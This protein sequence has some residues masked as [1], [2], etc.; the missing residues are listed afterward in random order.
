LHPEVEE[1][2]PS[3]VGDL[4][5]AHGV[6]GALGL[7][8]AMSA[9]GVSRARVRPLLEGAVRWLSA[10]AVTTE[11][12]PTFPTWIA[13]G[14][15]PKPARCAWCYG[16]PGIAAALLVAARGAGEPGWEREAVALACRAAERPVAETG[17]I[18]AGFCHGTAG[19]A[20]LYN[21]MY[22]ATGVSKLGRAARYWLERT[23]E[24]C[25]LAQGN[26]AVWVKGNE[27]L[28]EEGPWTGINLVAGAAGIGL[29]LL[30]ATTP[31]EPMWDRMF[32][33]S[34]PQLVSVAGT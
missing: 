24:F 25:R 15:E 9:A 19:L 10:Q 3:G 29:V 12:G 11:A 27:N 6:A 1:E 31:I 34:A 21:R 14:F 26:G 30:A 8:G 20:H 13:P 5:V 33:V 23:L 17:V 7:L 2:F 22:Q 28:E 16:D 32:L 18:D 4:G